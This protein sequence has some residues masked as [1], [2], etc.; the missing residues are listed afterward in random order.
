MS[1][2]ELA[3]MDNSKCI[4]QLRGERPFLSDKYDITRHPNYKFLSDENSYF[5][6][7]L[8]K[9]MNPAHQ[10][11]IKQVTDIFDVGAIESKL[12]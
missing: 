1:Q 6:F 4:L 2:Y 5:F 12:S 10:V 11:V 7:N 3:V 8:E 9:E